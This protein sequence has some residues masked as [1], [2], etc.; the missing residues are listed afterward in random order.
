MSS[1]Q[2]F[3]PADPKRRD[4][5]AESAFL[6]RGEVAWQEY[7]RTGILYPVDEVFDRI[8]NRIDAKRREL[9]VRLGDRD[10]SSSRAA[11]RP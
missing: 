6:A 2:P 8:Q 5:E 7:L 10:A 1:S 9:L 3:E 11:D 4:V